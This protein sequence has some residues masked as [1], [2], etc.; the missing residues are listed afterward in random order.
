MQFLPHHLGHIGCIETKACIVKR[1]GIGRRQRRVALLGGDP[2]QMGH[3]LQ[4]VI[5]TRQRRGGIGDR[6]DSG[7]R[8][9]KTRQ[10]R[11]FGQGQL[12]DA[13]AVIHSGCSLYTIGPLPQ[14]NLVEIKRQDFFFTQLTLDPKGKHDL[15]QFALIGLFRAQKEIARH[16]HGDGAAALFLFPRQRQARQR[17]QQ[18]LVIHTRMLKKPVVLRREHGLDQQWR[19]L[20][21][22]YGLPPLIAELTDEQP[23]L[24]VDP[25]GD[26]ELEI[27][28]GLDGGELR[29]EV[30]VQPQYGRCDQRHRRQHRSRQPA[31]KPDP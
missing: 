18:S 8:L 9:G 16:L 28:Q 5:T 22:R 2:A 31:E 24:S 14:I 19:E 25:Q 29:H 7:G 20:I 4:H 11:P 3:A 15:A 26:F 21:K 23:I 10:G 13:L 30:E 17:S 1:R 6:V 12:P 27:V